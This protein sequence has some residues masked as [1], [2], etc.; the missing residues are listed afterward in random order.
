MVKDLKKMD[1]W[2]QEDLEDGH[3]M[4]SMSKKLYR[5]QQSRFWDQ[6]PMPAEATLASHPLEAL[7]CGRCRH[8]CFSQKQLDAHMGQ[9]DKFGCHSCHM[10]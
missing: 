1:K 3:Y 2:G 9:H 4:Y 6:L 5:Y 10:T 7:E 8:R